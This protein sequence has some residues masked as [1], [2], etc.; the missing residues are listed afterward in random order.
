VYIHMFTLRAVI[1]I[2][3][4]LL[5]SSAF[6]PNRD[7]FSFLFNA[8][9]VIS[10]EIKRP[11][12]EADH[13][14]PSSV[15]LDFPH[16]PPWRARRKVYLYTFTNDKIPLRAKWHLIMT[17]MYTHIYSYIHTYTH[18]YVHIHACMHRHI[19]TYVHTHTYL[20]T[21]VTLQPAIK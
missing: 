12:R 18:T 15:N 6:L 13:L 17:Y 20:L 1:K 11:G 3:K 7:P 5:F 2:L 9:W 19:H 10:P 16:T 8:Y 14:L 4:N 21:K